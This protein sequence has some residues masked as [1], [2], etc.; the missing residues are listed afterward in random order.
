MIFPILCGLILIFI[1]IMFSKKPKKEKPK[2]I[3]IEREKQPVLIELFPK[4]TRANPYVCVVNS[5]VKLEVKGYS[6]YKKENEVELNAGYISWHKSCPVGRF[7]KEYGVKN[8]Y[9]TP[10][11]K[12]GRDIWIRYRDGKLFTSASLKLMIKVE[13]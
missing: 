2:P 8:I 1:I 12:G 11:V 7:D 9:H 6:D 4:G 5:E 13:V 10:S 3:V